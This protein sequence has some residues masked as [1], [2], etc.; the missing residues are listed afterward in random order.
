MQHFKSIKLFTK[1]FRQVQDKYKSLY[2]FLNF[3]R[4]FDWDVSLLLNPHFMGWASSCMIFNSPKMLKMFSCRKIEIRI[5]AATWQQMINMD[6]HPWKSFV[7]LLS[8]INR[9]N[10]NE[11]KNKSKYSIILNYIYKKYQRVGQIQLH[12][13]AVSC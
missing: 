2:I 4:S 12:H 9:W 7:I 8:R 1:V 11:C 6:K 10:E 5:Y 3:M 13:R